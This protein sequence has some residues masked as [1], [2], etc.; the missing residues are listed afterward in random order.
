VKRIFDPYSSSKGAGHGLGLA[1]VYATIDA[2][3]GGIRVLSALER[4]TTFEIFLPAASTLAPQEHPK[5]DDSGSAAGDILLVDDDDNILRT[6]SILLRTM[7]ATVHIAKDRHSALLQ[8]RALAP[9]LK[10]VIL[11]AHIGPLST[12]RLLRIYRL[13]A[14]NV[15]VV[16]TSGSSPEAIA[17]LFTEQPYNAFLAKPYTLAELKSA[18]ASAMRG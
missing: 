18:L 10:A 2:H 5:A 3:G 1:I 15:P 4:G 16:V 14:P 7:K 12:V 8:F 9:R 6:T 11:D 17:E 13:V